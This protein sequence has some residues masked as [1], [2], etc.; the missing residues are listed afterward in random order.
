V[1]TS[2]ANTVDGDSDVGDET[3]YRD[4][5]SSVESSVLVTNPEEAAKK[6]F[7]LQQQQQREREHQQRSRGFSQDNDSVPSSA[8][9]SSG[10]L[11]N[12][13]HSRVLSGNELSPLKLV[14]DFSP[15]LSS[16]DAPTS[17]T[18]A[19]S[20][21]SP[22]ARRGIFGPNRF[23]VRVSNS[24]DPTPS[25]SRPVSVANSQAVTVQEMSID[26]AIR[27]NSSLAKAI[28]IF[29]DDDDDDEDVS[30]GE[31][32]DSG[33]VIVRGRDQKPARRQEADE[34]AAMRASR[35]RSSGGEAPA[36]EE[37]PT[38]NTEQADAHA[39]DSIMSTFSTF[40][41][42]PNLTVFGNSPAKPGNLA[43][44]RTEPLEGTPSSNLL[45]E[46][47][48]LR[49]PSKSPSRRQSSPS[50]SVNGSNA[51]VTPQR[52]S[53]VMDFDIPPL[54]TPRSIPSIT[55]R[56]LESLKSNF[57]SEISSLKA[58]LSGKEAEVASLK[59]A[60]GDAEK[61]VGECMEQVR[62]ERAE[63]EVVVAEKDSWERRGREMDSVLRKVRDE[64]VHAQREREEL[65]SKLQ[66]SEMR[67]EAAEM[68]AQDAE[69][70]MAGLRAGKVAA[71]SRGSPTSGAPV[72]STREVEQAVE[73]VARELHALYK[74]KHETKVAALKKS[75]ETR[76]EKR[77]R[78]LEARL[79]ELTDD[80]DKL[81]AGLDTTMARV[82]P[83]EAAEE[84]RRAKSAR[85]AAQMRE[86][87]ADV[88]RLEAMHRAVKHD[89]DD[90]RRLLEQERVE[91]GELVQ[92][93]EEMMAMQQ[94]FAQA[95]PQPQ[96]PPPP[97]QQQQQQ[98]QYVQEPQQ[99]QYVQ[100]QQQQFAQQPQQQQYAQQPQQQQYAQ[101]Q[102]SQYAQ[103][104]QPQYAQQPQSQY[105]QQPPPSQYAQRQPQM[106]A[107]RAQ[108]PLHHQQSAA[109]VPSPRKS[110]PPPARPSG[111]G[112]GGKLTAPR[113]A[114]ASG[115]RAPGSRIGGGIPAPA[116]SAHGRANSAGG[117]PRPGGAGGNPMRSSVIGGI[118]QMA[119]R[120]E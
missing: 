113:I 108:S 104:Q 59:T 105:A 55:P 95:P 28:D 23:P 61:R 7:L 35:G 94:S 102:Q 3:S 46:F 100:P 69:S 76:W 37:A 5:H 57:L 54:P 112:G 6:R 10:N 75:Y 77:V 111:I 72:N 82:G 20:A 88:D 19:T 106:S 56:E 74:S 40:S 34:V 101:P 29:E 33:S 21:R 58:S 17:A 83:D 66:E 51:A 1:P 44:S 38:M 86:L 63:R 84:E 62:E 31:G 117:L 93:A 9:S 16:G 99:Q 107:P 90:L 70:K 114:P 32:S 87:A 81:R 12:N 4:A 89:N 92:L 15:T 47:T 60:V 68:M 36:R 48:D 98:Q 22:A 41:A 103:P 78:E 116:S 11:A 50:R 80:N 71:E 30:M 85:D 27:S 91:K 2:A 43:R 115:L 52:P 64:M 14:G 18:S 8:S 109:A 42:V 53:N 97:Q 39:D 118:N 13:R 24:T 120:R 45:S 96:A 119:Y 110:M 25:S 67:R 79:E 73:R 49:N 26:E 65:E